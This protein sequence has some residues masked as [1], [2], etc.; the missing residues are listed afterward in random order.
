MKWRFILVAVFLGAIRP[1]NLIA[2]PTTRPTPGTRQTPAMRQ[3]VL[4]CAQIKMRTSQLSLPA[5]SEVYIFGLCAGGAR[6]LRHEPASVKVQNR[7]GRLVAELAVCRSEDNDFRTRCGWYIIGGCGLSGY[8]YMSAVCAPAI[9][10]TAKQASVSF[11]L[12]QP[13]LIVV[14]GFGAA[15]S[16]LKFAGIAGLKVAA[17]STAGRL[18]SAIAQANCPPGSYTVTQSADSPDRGPVQEVLG[19]FALSNQPDAMESVNQKLNLPRDFAEPGTAPAVLAETGPKGDGNAVTIV[20]M[21]GGGNGGISESVI[22]CA[23]SLAG[24]VLLGTLIVAMVAARNKER[25]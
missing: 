6:P 22:I 20:A 15:E 7:R 25:P 10:Q 2:G 3:A 1:V 17:Q 5:G 13:A 18:T 14:M 24:I 11:T 8:S 9:N 4:E 19:V 21:P 12:R 23:A 16:R